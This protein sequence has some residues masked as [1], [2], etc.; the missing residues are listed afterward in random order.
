MTERETLLQHVR[1][2]N[3]AMIE[4][5]LFLNS[6]P[7]NAAALAYFQ[8]Q[9]AKYDEAVKNYEAK[10]GPLMTL[11]ANESSEWQWIAAPWPWEGADN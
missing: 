8:S 3:F 1:M 9:K 6:H 10:Y 11:R 5:G 2:H 4:T 7:R